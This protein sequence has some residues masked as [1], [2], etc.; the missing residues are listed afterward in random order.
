MLVAIVGAGRVGTALA[1]LWR[2]AG[3]RITAVSGREATPERVARFL[4]EIPVRAP[5]DAVRD[6]SLAVIATPDSAIA[7][8]CK[9]IA[10]ARAAGT[11][12][13]HVSG[14]MGLDALDA[15][16][17]VGATILS[18]HPLQSFPSVEAAIERLPGAAF[19]VSA[20]E[21]EGFAI[22]ERMALDAGGRPFRLDESMKPLYHA[23]AVFA[24]NYLVTITAVAEELDR[25]AGVAEPIGALAPLQEATLANVRQGGPATALT[26]PAVRGDA[27]TIARNL[28][29]LEAH[30]PGAVAAYVALAELTLD[31]AERSGRLP[32]DARA[33]VEEVLARWR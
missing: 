4:P 30:A 16:R 26:G 5:A 23:A 25:A 3:H 24:S 7:S 14:A 31:L 13:A 9:A 27:V 29:A 32:S 15:A 2:R 17:S 20:F 11:A 21:E 28:E 22:G 19:A 1:V 6:A 33:A 12:V 18:L 8:A 10:V